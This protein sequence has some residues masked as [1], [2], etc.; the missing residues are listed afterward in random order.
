[1]ISR[2]AFL[3]Q[4]VAA[5][6]APTTMQ[7]QVLQ[8]STIGVNVPLTGDYA[9]YGSQIVA[10]VQAAIDETNRYNSTLTRAWGIRTFDDR[11]SGTV[12][13]SNV[14]VAASDPSIVGMIGD[15]TADVTLTALPQYA[16]ANFA[17][18]VP[19]VTADVITAR[20]YRNVFRLPTSDANEGILM[21][22]A[23]ID[24]GNSSKVL[25]LVSDGDAYGN[26]IASAFV[27]QAKADRHTVELVT[28][29][30]N[31]EPKNAAAVAIARTPSLVFL[32]GRPDKLG[33]IALTMREQGYSGPFAACDA[34]YSAQIP[35]MYGKA[36][37]GMLVASSLAPLDR[38][39]SI[40]SYLRDFQNEVSAISAFSAYGYAAAQ[41]IVQASGRANATNRFQVLNQLQQG[42]S[43][44]LLVGQFSFTYSGDATQPNIY[45]YSL[46][47]TGFT[48]EKPAVASGF[49]V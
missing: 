37:G 42:G 35:K 8:Q 36:L 41:L 20:G 39:P 3:Q 33:P 1:M 27:A 18:V 4:S 49:V 21:A 28:F 38:A 32:A 12:A 43:Y 22:R 40:I 46:G 34:F 5:A 6:L 24:R 19:S 14:F 17:I 29:D 9:P 10:G 26:A 23:A 31:E 2:A 45:L 44:N 30:A 47:A 11:N 16:N 48:F 15:L 7:G 25:A 13:S